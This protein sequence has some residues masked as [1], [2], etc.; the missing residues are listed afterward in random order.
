MT[1]LLIDL[2]LQPVILEVPLVKS[3]S[4]DLEAL[5]RHLIS[6]SSSIDYSLGH[7]NN[8]TP[9]KGSSALPGRYHPPSSRRLPASGDDVSVDPLR[10]DLGLVA[11]LAAPLAPIYPP[12][13]LLRIR[14]AHQSCKTLTTRPDPSL[15]E[16]GHLSSRY[17][18]I[19]L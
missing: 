8:G 18:V 16:R 19:S 4:I 2:L 12:P 1:F 6:R 14:T 15:G 13:P 10:S 11:V 3:R 7:R 5:P 9:E 17:I